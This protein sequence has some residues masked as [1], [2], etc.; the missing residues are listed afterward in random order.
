MKKLK[1]IEFDPFKLIT[2]AHG[3]NMFFERVNLL[4][5]TGEITTCGPI[6]DMFALNV[7]SPE[8]LYHNVGSGGLFMDISHTLILERYDEAKII[9]YV[10]DVLRKCNSGSGKHLWR[11]LEYY[12]VT[13][14]YE[15]FSE[16]TVGTMEI[17]E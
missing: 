7:T 12:F 1:L 5:G 3:N 17:S 16:S 6:Q 15:K 9:K 8:W 11:E 4:I 13:F 10:E 2:V 14:N